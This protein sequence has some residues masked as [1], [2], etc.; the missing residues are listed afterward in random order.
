MHHLI[1]A[2]TFQR[3]NGNACRGYKGKFL[4]SYYPDE[5]LLEYTAQR[6]W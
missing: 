2:G 6:G 1:Y 4:L 5:C 3:A